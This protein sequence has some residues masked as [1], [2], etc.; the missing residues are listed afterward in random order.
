MGNEGKP[1]PLE[2]FT[3]LPQTLTRIDIFSSMLS[4]SVIKNLGWRLKPP[5][6]YNMHVNMQKYNMLQ[7]TSDCALSLLC[8][9]VSK[10]DIRW[11]R[12]MVYAVVRDD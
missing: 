5:E 1:L 9:I 2:R 7:E 12:T 10:R 3:P 8:V 6:K 4:C 11:I